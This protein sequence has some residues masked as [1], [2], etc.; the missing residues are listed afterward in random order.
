MQ[1]IAVLGSTGSIGTNCLE[2]IGGLP[3]RLSL[4]GVAARSSWQLL[5][6]QTE[7]FAP[8]WAVLSDASLKN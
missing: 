5:G 2:V 8:R 1:R 3:D 4:C 6:R 7:R